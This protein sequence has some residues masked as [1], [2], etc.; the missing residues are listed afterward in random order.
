MNVMIRQN[1]NVAV[2]TYFKNAPT[3]IVFVDGVESANSSSCGIYNFAIGSRS[4]A[5]IVHAKEF[6]PAVFEKISIISPAKN[7][8]I[9]TQFLWSDN[10]SLMI[11]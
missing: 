4:A 10:G 6:I 11:K 9:I 2:K 8:I 5:R 7:E 1:T 3:P